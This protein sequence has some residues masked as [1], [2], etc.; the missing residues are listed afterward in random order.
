MYKASVEFCRRVDSLPMRG[1][2]FQCS[3][4]RFL[5]SNGKLEIANSRSRLL[6][7]VLVLVWVVC[8]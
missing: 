8:C 4:I 7:L 1:E 2:P 6:A 5:L 3:S